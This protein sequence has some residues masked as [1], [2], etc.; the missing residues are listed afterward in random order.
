MNAKKLIAAA[1]VF[2]ATGGAFAA[3]APASNAAVTAAAAS[4]TATSLNVPAINVSATRTRAEVRAEAIEYVKNY[5]TT[6]A[7]QLEQY[8]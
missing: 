6:L 7:L 3:E 1:A 4:V 5:K 8:K 2:L